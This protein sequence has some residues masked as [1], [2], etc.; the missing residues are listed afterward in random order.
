[1]LPPWCQLSDGHRKAGALRVRTH[2]S[3]SRLFEA[4]FGPCAE[5]L[6]QWAEQFIAAVA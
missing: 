4:I 2:R 6:Y 1:M 5:G 3:T